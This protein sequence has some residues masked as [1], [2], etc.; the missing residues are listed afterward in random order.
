MTEPADL[1]C[2]IDDDASLRRA[3]RRLLQS[4][5][6]RV[7]VYASGDEFLEAEIPSQPVCAICDLSM[8]GLDGLELQARLVDA[9]V[10]CG[11][12]FLTGHGDLDSGVR[13]MK[14]G[15]VDFLCK[16]VDETRLL[17]AVD[18][19]LRRQRRRF[20]ETAATDDA[21]RR[22]ESLTPRELDVLRLV[23]AGRLNKLIAAE[24]G[25]SEKTVKAH[26]SKVMRKTGA[27]SL[28][29]LVRLY[30]AASKDRT[31]GSSDP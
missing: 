10:E 27:R 28:A 29:E 17:A 18:E 1:V 30:I 25:I 21:R 3:L 26:R 19:S 7:R 20:D 9:G 8:P 5:G 4:A 6:Y 31:A 22:F 13:A 14:H 15:A 11:I 2:V 12:V 16:P 23:V 24:L